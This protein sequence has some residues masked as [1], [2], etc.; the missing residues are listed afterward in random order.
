MEY[1]INSHLQPRTFH[2][3]AAPLARR[4]ASPLCDTDGRA[5]HPGDFHLYS[6]RE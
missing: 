2:S 1:V 5:C 4:L 6:M 3:C